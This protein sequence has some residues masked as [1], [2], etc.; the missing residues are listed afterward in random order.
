MAGAEQT[1][2]TTYTAETETARTARRVSSVLSGDEELLAMPDAVPGNIWHGF[3][4]LHHAP[5]LTVVDASSM[6]YNASQL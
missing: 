2:Q 6:H 3:T 5:Q 1:D 4:T